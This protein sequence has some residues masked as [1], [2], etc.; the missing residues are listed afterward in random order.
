MNISEECYNDI[1][2]LVEQHINKDNVR[3]LELARLQKR[4]QELMNS[5]ATDKVRQTA[6]GKSVIGAPDVANELNSIKK[7]IQELKGNQGGIKEALLDLIKPKKKKEIS[8]KMLELR[9][10]ILKANRKKEPPKQKKEKIEVPKI[11][12]QGVFGEAIELTEAMIHEMSKELTESLIDEAI[13]ILEKIT[14]S[15]VKQGAEN[16]IPTRKAQEE[17]ASSNLGEVIYPFRGAVYDPKNKRANAWDEAA[18]RLYRAERLAKILPNSNRSGAELKATAKRVAPSRSKENEAAF[19]NL[20]NI[21]KEFFSKHP[22]ERTNS[23][24]DTLK[25]AHKDYWKKQ[26][27]EDEAH[28]IIGKKLRRPEKDS[29]GNYKLKDQGF[30]DRSEG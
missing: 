12:V 2:D 8:P 4:G 1:I 6:D 3:S 22:T 18:Y 20:Q 10:R 29:S 19:N 17:K 14:V 30:I 23:D 5:G 16:S 26:N 11:T 25:K 15:Q 9:D 13:S 27:R 7:R 28:L 21:S 24:Y